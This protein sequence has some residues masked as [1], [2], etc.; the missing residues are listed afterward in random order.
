MV[1][2][3][4]VP[5]S[6]RRASERGRG[7]RRP[8]Y[9]AGGSTQ[10]VPSWSNSAMRSSGGTKSLLDG[11]V[12]ARTKSRIA[13]FAGPSFHRSSALVWVSAAVASRS[14]GGADIAA[15]APSTRRR[16]GPSGPTVN[17]TIHLLN[18][19]PSLVGDPTFQR[20]FTTSVGVR[21]P[22]ARGRPVFARLRYTI[23]R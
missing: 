10:R 18:H 6:F 1:H 3:L 22:H 16:L 23:Q 13:C 9:R 12:A 5:A 7:R 17:T 14:P 15:S 11:S 8:A 2:G 21:A 4:S 20:A 19:C